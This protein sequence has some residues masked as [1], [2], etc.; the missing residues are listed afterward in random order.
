MKINETLTRMVLGRMSAYIKKLALWGLMHCA[1][2]AMA[3]V[4]VIAEMSGNA[5]FYYSA[6]WRTFYSGWERVFYC[7]RNKKD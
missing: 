3:P 6:I 5:V 2:S 1:K 4:P 7:S